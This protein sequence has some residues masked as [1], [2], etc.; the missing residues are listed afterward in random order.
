MSESAPRAGDAVVLTLLAILVAALVVLAVLAGILPRIAVTAGVAG[1]CV[2]VAVLAAAV[3]ASGAGASTLAVPIG[4][5]G[6][7]MHL[8][9]DPLAASFLLLLFLVMPCAET[10]PLPLAASG[11]HRAG[12]RRF[13]AG[14][15]SAVAGRRTARCAS[16]P[17][18]RSA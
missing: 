8:A 18:P 14:R 7:S 10:A 17:L 13:F 15:G 16:Q 2:L 11:D 9:L 6:A 12:G 3:L 5:P 1:I 4:P